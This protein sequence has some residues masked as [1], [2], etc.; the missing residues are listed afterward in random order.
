MSSLLYDICRAKWANKTLDWANDTIKLA[1]VTASYAPNVGTHVSMAD[2]TNE[3][4]TTGYAR[5]TLAN[6]SIV[7][8]TSLHRCDFKA[9]NPTWTAIGTATSPPVAAAAIIYKDVDGTDANA[10]LLG[11]LDNAD[12]ALNGGDFTLKFDGQASNGRVLSIA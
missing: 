6:K 3:L 11:Y 9:D 7:N 1:L 8:D 10:I 12:Q 2:V 5:K 4:S